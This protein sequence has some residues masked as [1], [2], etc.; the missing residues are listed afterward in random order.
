MTAP[1]C[2][3]SV[4]YGYLIAAVSDLKISKH[5][6]FSLLSTASLKKPHCYKASLGAP[7]FVC[8]CTKLLNL[9]RAAV[10]FLCVKLKASKN[11]LPKSSSLPNKFHSRKSTHW[12]L[13]VPENGA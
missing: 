6:I 1:G 13:S 2:R 4:G 8:V 10:G 9:L 5:I 7:E 3:K 11:S 12:K